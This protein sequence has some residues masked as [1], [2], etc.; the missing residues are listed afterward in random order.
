MTLSP[1]TQAGCLVTLLALVCLSAG[2]ILGIAA[3]QAWKKK[4][5]DPAFMRWAALKHLEKLK[6]SPEQRPAIEAKVDAAV[7]ELTDFRQSA[8]KQ[9]WGILDRTSDSLRE[10][11]TPEQQ[12]AWETLR[13]KP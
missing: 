4:T 8:L 2:F 10:D 3:H 11:L 7:K 13:P 9:I 1:R 6:L 5:E 12:K